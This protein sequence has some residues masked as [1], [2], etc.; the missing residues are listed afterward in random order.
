MT[1]N[2][3]HKNLNVP[4]LRFTVFSVEWVETELQDIV[5]NICS[6]KDRISNSGEVALY[7]STVEC[8]SLMPHN[9]G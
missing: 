1:K 4:D 5:P 2:N 7:G 8:N 3:E 9:S 6:G